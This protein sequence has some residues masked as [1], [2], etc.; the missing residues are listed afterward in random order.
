MTV[1]FVAIVGGIAIAAIRGLA[2]WRTFRSFERSLDRMVADTTRLVDGVE[3]RVA[4]AS[5]TAARLQ[6]AR[7]RLEASVATA[8]VLFTALGEARALV[9][10]VSAFVPR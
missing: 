6:E 5:E 2:A 4:R 10:R 3:P 1:F 9:R 7:E 8:A